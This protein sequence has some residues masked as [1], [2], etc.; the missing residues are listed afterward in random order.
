MFA[1]SC[2]GV[3]KINN[4]CFL[5][6]IAFLYKYILIVKMK[7]VSILEMELEAF[8]WTRGDELK[9]KEVSRKIHQAVL[10]T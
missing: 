9:R 1:F 10:R 6:L 8:C 4:S 7:F 3:R 5:S 2:V